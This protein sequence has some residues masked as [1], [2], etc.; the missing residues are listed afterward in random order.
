MLQF[1]N[2][3]RKELLG[4]GSEIASSKSDIS[5]SVGVTWKCLLILNFK[6]SIQSNGF[7]YDIY[8]CMCQYTFQVSPLC[9]YTG[10][11]VCNS[12]QLYY[13]MAH[14]LA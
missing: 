2:L 9:L 6:G 12:G 3:G 13:S 10:K 7:H 8:T 14:L 11:S 1:T 4:E 5:Q